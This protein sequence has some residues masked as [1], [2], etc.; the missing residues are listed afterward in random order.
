MAEQ[1]SRRRPTKR[2]GNTMDH[3][4][5]GYGARAL[6]AMLLL[7][8]A[9]VEAIAVKAPIQIMRFTV[10]PES[11]GIQGPGGIEAPEVLWYRITLG[12][13]SHNS[14]LKRFSDFEAFVSEGIGSKQIG[15]GA[16]FG[17]RNYFARKCHQMIWF[18]KLQ[19]PFAVVNVASPKQL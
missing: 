4:S 7:Y 8:I 12:Q 10:A 6:T 5:I 2:G 11:H 13:Q 15:D 1:S 9:G 16:I 18:C 17:I 3:A 19:H 14:I